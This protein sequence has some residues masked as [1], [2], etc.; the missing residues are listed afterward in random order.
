MR[1]CQ[2]ATSGMAITAAMLA[3]AVPC[4]AQGRPAPTIVLDRGAKEFADPFSQLGALIELR[5]GRVV[6]MDGKEKLLN[7]VDFAAGTSTP[8]SRVGSGPMEYKIPGT[9]FGTSRDTVIYFDMAQQR[10]LV[11]SP[12]GKPVRTVPFA[13]AKDPL[14][15]LRSAIPSSGDT[16]GHL[17]G[18]SIGITM[19]RPD[20][21]T[22]SMMPKF[23]DTVDVM[24]MERGAT[25][26]TAMTRIRNVITKSQPKM[27][28][29]GTTFKITITAPDYRAND[30]WTALPDGRI[31]L[32]RD[33]IYRIHIVTAGR[34]ETLGPPI[35]FTPVPVT[36]AERKAMVDSL[37]KATTEALKATG[38][39]SAP[40][41][42]IDFQVVEP[43]TWAAFKPAYV[44]LASSPD[45]RLWVSLSSAAG[46]PAR[47][48]VLDGM[49]T[50][51]AHV[52]LAAGEH[53]VGWGRG[54]LYTVRTD[55][56]DLQ[57]L[58]RYALPA[59]R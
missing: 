3:T 59:L 30:S 11:L 27:E 58:R 13:D 44:N 57:Y 41:V 53:P 16:L 15:M 45:G 22:A 26:G 12:G 51:L 9:L 2:Q 36:V 20:A 50:L 23:A 46:A 39:E 38:A 18:Q 55:Q 37:K 32:L 56:D 28:M 17:F 48:D 21:G 6:V 29:S 33:G 35:A 10:M 1:F 14:A 19:P 24:R 52:Q 34:P 8:V 25:S 43:Q 49:G 47:I 40:G 5:D 4:A 42:K 31:A 54:T 7:V